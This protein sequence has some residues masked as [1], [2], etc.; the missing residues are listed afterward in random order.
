MRI[1]TIPFIIAFAIS[2]LIAYA[3]Y[4]FSVGDNKTLIAFGS[5]VFLLISSIF[6]ISVSFDEP[7]TTTN[8]RIVSGIFFSIAI[9]SNIIFTFVSFSIPIYIITNGI[10][11]L[12]YL[13]IVYSIQKVKQ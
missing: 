12:I 13:L 1:N 5:F 2:L 7:R 3:F 11:L 8:I 4:S 10:F 9:I 6:A